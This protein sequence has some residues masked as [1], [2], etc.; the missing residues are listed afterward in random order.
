MNATTLH[1]KEICIQW[2]QS[3]TSLGLLPS[4]E[5]MA[6][7]TESTSVGSFSDSRLV[8]SFPHHY[9]VKL[10]DGNYV[11]WQQHVRLITEGYELQDFLDGTLPVPARFVTSLDGTLTPNPNASFFIQQDKLLASWLLSTISASLLSYFIFFKK[12]CKIWNTTNRLFSATTGAKLSR[13][14]HGL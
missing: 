14:K 11:Q 12:G 2:Y 6:N 7:S 10:D 8:Q 9:T 1:S 4:I 3:P 5:S 13:I